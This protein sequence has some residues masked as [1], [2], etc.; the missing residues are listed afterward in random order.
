MQG[1]LEQHHIHWNFNLPRAPWWGGQ[2]E[3]LIGVMKHAFNKTIGAASLT[4]EELTAVVLDVE[5]QLNHRPLSYVED[6]VQLP[7][8]TPSAFLFQR[9]PKKTR[10]VPQ[11]MQGPTLAPLDKGISDVPS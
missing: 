3:R 2:F 4:W 5:I 9:L 8:L 11:V 6:D 7:I 1:L 10:K